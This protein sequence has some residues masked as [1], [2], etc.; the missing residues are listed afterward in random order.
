MVVHVGKDEILVLLDGSIAAPTKHRVTG[1]PK[2]RLEW[3]MSSALQGSF[4]PWTQPFVPQFTCEPWPCRE[5]FSPDLSGAQQL[6][7]QALFCRW[8]PDSRVQDLTRHPRTNRG[9]KYDLLWIMELPW[10]THMCNLNRYVRENAWSPTHTEAG[11]RSAVV[12]NPCVAVM[13]SSH[14]ECSGFNPALQSVLPLPGTQ[15]QPQ[16]CR[17]R[18]EVGLHADCS[19]VTRYNVI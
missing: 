1:L 13:Q 16:A 17:A 7:V 3:N 5:W 4:C 10:W 12:G 8:Q 6:C 14:S 2:R 19:A 11:S 15:T 9:W 18:L